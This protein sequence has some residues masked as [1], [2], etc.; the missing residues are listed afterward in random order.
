M[1]RAAY[2]GGAKHGGKG[3][4]QATGHREAEA[5]GELLGCLHGLR[6][7]LIERWDRLDRLLARHTVGA[8]LQGMVTATDQRTNW[9][10]PALVLGAQKRAGNALPQIRQ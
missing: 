10:D 8:T 7:G 5:R 4:D 2:E 1:F 3:A 6:G 9:I